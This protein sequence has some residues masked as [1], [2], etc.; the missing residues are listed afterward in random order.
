MLGELQRSTGNSITQQAQ[1]YLNY[2]LSTWI[3][4]WEQ[5]IPFTFGIDTDEMFI[6]FDVDRLLRAD[7]T[8]RFA[9]NRVAL[10]GTGWMTMNEVRGNEGLPDVEGGDTVFRPVNT[11]P[12][13]SDV[14][15]GS[16]D[17]SDPTVPGDT[18]KNPPAV[19][20]DQTG[21]KAEGGGRPSKKDIAKT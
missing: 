12:L 3:E 1:E 19:G 15:A 2:S 14:F 20:S 9:A 17:P 7:I 6:K 5:R 16:P 10:G 8:T 13:D 4:M 18:N 11:A 21:Q